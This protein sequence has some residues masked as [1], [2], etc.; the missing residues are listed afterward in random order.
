MNWNE[1]D[2]TAHESDDTKQ[3]LLLKWVLPF[4]FLVVGLIVMALL[5]FI[6]ESPA[7]TTPEE[8]SAL[9]DVV[10][11]APTTDRIEIVGFGAV[12][13]D[14]E[15][16]VQP[17]V[18][19]YVVAKNK[20][21][22][23]GGLIP[24]EAELFQIDPR[25]YEIAVEVAKAEVARSELE[26]ALE[27]G[28]QV[29]AK[30]E[31]NLLED[32]VVT[33]ELGKSLAL[34]EPHF[35]A[36]RAALSASQSRLKKAKLDVERTSIKAPFDAVVIDEAIELGK[37]LTPQTV[38][39]RLVATDTFYITAR[40]P[41]KMLPSLPEPGAEVLVTQE[42]GSGDQ[43][44]R[45]GRL[46]RRLSDVDAVGRMPQ[47]LIA[48]DDP[49]ALKDPAQ[50]A[51]LLG[52]QVRVVLAGR[53]VS[54]VFRIPRAA[55]REGNQVWVRNGEGR[56]EYRDVEVVFGRK[57]E[58]VVVGDLSSGEELVVSPLQVALPGM[59]LALLEENEAPLQAPSED[60]GGE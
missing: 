33:S 2:T 37:Y 51:L 15:L 34:R 3:I 10:T 22:E 30:R 53:E 24:K 55:L 13:P 57:D 4:A 21:L 26:Y 56:L 5:I 16:I 49:L 19:G 12:A 39:A 14:Q 11:L 38:A 50:E 44:M 54:R 46:V 1:I 28:N 47:I 58:I 52:S 18:S 32:S 45:K 31:W 8:K 60:K 35:E 27:E 42:L 6:R 20:A 43:I 9:V 23:V 41:S 25:D 48:V 59:L 7:K 36:Q 17:Q 40:I 29:V